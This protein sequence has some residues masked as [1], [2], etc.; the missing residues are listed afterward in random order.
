[1]LPVPKEKMTMESKAAQPRRIERAAWEN[2]E[3]WRTRWLREGGRRG[4][5]A[6][7]RGGVHRATFSLEKGFTAM[8]LR[9]WDAK[10]KI[11][12]LLTY[13]MVHPEIDMWPDYTQHFSKDQRSGE[14]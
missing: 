14:K 12:F 11:L 7:T 1:M 4:L 10:C 8:T 9:D 3:G 2:L 6:L 5:S 13:L